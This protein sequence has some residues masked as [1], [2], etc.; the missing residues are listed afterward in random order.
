M[1][2]SLYKE[3]KHKTV[4]TFDCRL[5]LISECC[6]IIERKREY[7]IYIIENGVIIIII[8]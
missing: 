1:K 6:I 7:E 3:G 4:I 2:M 5:A 8:I